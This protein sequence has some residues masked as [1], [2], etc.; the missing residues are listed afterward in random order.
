M[1][2]PVAAGR[3]YLQLAAALPPLLVLPVLP[4]PAVVLFERYSCLIPHN[5]ELK[6]MIKSKEGNV[7]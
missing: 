1:K 4:A 5:I 2:V 7:L 3:H 6:I